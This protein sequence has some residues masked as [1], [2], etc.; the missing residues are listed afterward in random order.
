MN[1][2]TWD[3]V[4][5]NGKTISFRMPEPKDGAAVNRLIAEVDD[6]VIGFVSAMLDL[7]ETTS[8]FVWQNS[9]VDQSRTQARLTIPQV[10]PR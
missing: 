2:L 9:L 6:R 5:R 10:R 7:R 8:L 1:E 3:E 4:E